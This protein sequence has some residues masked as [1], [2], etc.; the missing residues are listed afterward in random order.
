MVQ[1]D[2]SNAKIWQ[3]SLSTGVWKH[4]ATATQPTAETSGIVDV[5][6]WFGRGWWAVTVQS[7]VNQTATTGTPFVWTG[8]PGPPV[9]TTYQMRREDGQL[10]LMKI[11]GS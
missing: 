11:A 9:G 3:Y 6:R 2:T 8:P 7:H 10:L 1:E 4:V 5:S